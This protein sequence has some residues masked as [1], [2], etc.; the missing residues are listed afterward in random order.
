MIAADR[1][2]V[3]LLAAGL[4]RRFGPGDKLLAEVDRK[5]L[6]AHAADTLAGIGFGSLIAVCGSDP[7]AELLSGRG[8]AVVRNDRP[9]EGQSRSIR[10]GVEAASDH[11]AV[12]I[13]LADMPYVS[14]GHYRRQLAA[15]EPGRVI[16]S[17]TDGIAQP[18][19]LF[20]RTN[21]GSLL[22]LAGD[23][24]AKTLLAGAM[25]VE[26]GSG[27]LADIDTPGATPPRPAPSA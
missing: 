3:V 13:C 17:T 8:F 24:G 21:Y 1:V 20:D 4:S 19:A 26:A 10:L 16:A 9:E 5:P 14:V 6:A 12:L 7:V 18:P 11:D 27:E 15:H 23:H 2:A 25:L 22:K